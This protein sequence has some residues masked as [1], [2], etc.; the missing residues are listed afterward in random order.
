[1]ENSNA[2]KIV[3]GILSFVI[4]LGGATY[5]VWNF[6][7]EKTNVTMIVDGDQINFDAGED[8]SVSNILPV[9][10]MEEGITKDVTVYK[11]N[12]NYRAGIDLYLN[13]K[14]WPTYL[15]DKS[16]RWALFKNGKYLSSGDFKNYKQGNNVKLTNNT[17]EL[18][19]ESDKDSYNLY[20]WID[21]YQETNIN[22][23]NKELVV[24]LYGQVSFYD[25]DEVIASSSSPN[26]P[27]LI[28]GMIPVVYN[29]ILDEW[30]KADSSN[31]NNSWYNYEEKY[32]ANAVMVKSDKRD[33]YMNASVGV[34]VAEDDILAYY[35]WIPRYRYVLFNVNSTSGPEE[36]QIEFQKTTD[37]ISSGSSNLEYLTHPAFWWDSDS[38]G[39]REDGEEISG[40]WIGKFETSGSISNPTIKP[41]LVSATGINV[42][43]LFNM[44]KRFESTDYLTSTGVE[45]ADSHMIKNIEWGA[46]ALLSHSRYGTNTEVCINNNSNFL[47]GRS[48]G[49]TNGSY[50]Y[51]DFYVDTSGN[52]TINKEAGMGVCA[53]SSG[54]VSGVYDMSGGAWE[55]VM[56]VMKNS[57][58]TINYSSSGFNANNMVESKYYDLYE[59]S[60][61]VNDYTRRILGD[62]TGETKGWYSDYS[63][64]IY[65][66]NSWFLRGGYWC[67]G[68]GA[69]PFAF[70]LNTG[71]AYGSGGSRAVLLPD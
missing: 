55:Y 20:L 54:N 49:S 41:N 8:I 12:G 22:L 53:S 62:A 16:F 46:V 13:L 37:E 23:M 60:D 63:S 2:K 39:V 19:L 32:W 57:L 58:G 47:T 45:Q 44:N 31:T 1:M 68:S 38:D 66:N 9:Y 4:L 69:G 17:Q 59:Y 29:F 61:S 71:T 34:N 30:Q 40:F 35:V 28:D 43:N 10:T 21:A 33:T 36:I 18:H 25:N 11:E 52:I 50:T 67:N 6:L 56:G 65:S 27:L 48:T 70:S 7:T 24:S 26:E 64:F 15:S 14:T 5:A 3:I 51:N 42:Y